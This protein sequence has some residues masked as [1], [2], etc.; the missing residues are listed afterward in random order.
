M[1]KGEKL[2][3]VPIAFIIAYAVVLALITTLVCAN[4]IFIMEMFSAEMLFKL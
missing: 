4:S 1:M 3:V 2:C